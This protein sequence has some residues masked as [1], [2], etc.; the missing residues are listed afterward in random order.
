MKEKDQVIAIKNYFLKSWPELADRLFVDSTTI[1]VDF[2]ENCGHLSSTQELLVKLSYSMWNDL[3]Q[4]NLW[5]V[6]RTL[7]D[8]DLKNVIEGLEYLRKKA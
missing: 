5:E 3:G 7:E 8:K 4:V 6:F 2:V 1:D